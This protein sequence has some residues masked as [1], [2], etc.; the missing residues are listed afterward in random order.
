[1][2]AH[3]DT[4]TEP[5]T[6]RMV[7]IVVG[8]HV[9][10]ELGDRPIAYGLRDVMAGALPAGLT[11]VVVT[12]VWYLNSQELRARPTISVGGPARNAL[13]AHL[14]DRVPSAYVADDR[15]IV[16]L[17][18]GLADLTACCWG[19]DDAATAR[20]VAVFCERHAE[21]WARAVA[22]RDGAA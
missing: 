5:R 18:V 6:D 15:Y 20:A 16:Q 2:H 11:P 17:D 4:E 14:G 12:D 3:P 8:A 7:P 22:A 1:M 13:T 19:V 9:L 21:R 10:A